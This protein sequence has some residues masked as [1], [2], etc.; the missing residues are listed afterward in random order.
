MPVFRLYGAKGLTYRYSINGIFKELV[1]PKSIS[2]FFTLMCDTVA[3]EMF[4]LFLCAMDEA[5]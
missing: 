4:Q 3:D 1:S 2:L 5:K